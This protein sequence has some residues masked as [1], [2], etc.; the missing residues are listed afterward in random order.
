MEPMCRALGLGL[1][2]RVQGSGSGGCARAWPLP[3]APK[4]HTL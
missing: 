4:T 2:L 3:Q 1:G